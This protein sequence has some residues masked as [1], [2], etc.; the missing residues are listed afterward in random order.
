M[1]YTR[2]YADKNGDSH[3]EDVEVEM[4][5][6]DFAPPAPPLDLSPAMPSTNVAFLGSPAGWDSEPHPAPRRLLLIYLTGEAE[7]TVSDGEARRFGPGSVVLAE[8]T[9]GKGHASRAV[10]DG[11]V[12]TAVV[13]LAA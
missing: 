7:I 8:D 2:I 12:L 6:V 10:G 3:F 13:Q 9:S 1:K 11:N 5:L 4:S